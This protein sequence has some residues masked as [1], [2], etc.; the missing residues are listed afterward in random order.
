MLQIL[1]VTFGAG[2]AGMLLFLVMVKGSLAAVLV[3][4][5]SPLP[6]MIAALGWHQAAGLGAALFGALVIG[7][8]I[9]PSAGLLYALGFALPAWWLAYLCLLARFPAGTPRRDRSPGVQRE[10]Y[11]IGRIMV[12]AALLA[13]GVAI[14]GIL[15]VSSRHGGFD[16]AA[17]SYAAYIVPAVKTLFA[18]T[19]GLPEGIAVEDLAAAVL[20]TVPVVGA[21]MQMLI[22][23]L[24][25][26]LA[27]RTVAFSQ[28]LARPWP[29]LPENLRAPRILAGVVPAF[30]LTAIVSGDYVALFAAVLLATL[31]GVLMLQGFAVVHALTRHRPGR[32]AML[33][34]FY[35]AFLIFMPWSAVLLAFLGLVDLAV[36]LRERFAIAPSSRTHS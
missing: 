4:S 20:R 12:W 3:A 26:W 24:N 15:I 27:G 36:P 19:G 31:G 16:R 6:I 29:D 30:V 33:V 14:G 28:R 9:A 34:A 13:A 11:P 8:T 2:L 25:L 23:L 17:Q 10:W 22:L 5:F 21:T 18:S 1:L 32:P 7:A 35:A